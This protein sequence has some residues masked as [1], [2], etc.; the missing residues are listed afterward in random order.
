MGR[1]Q[2]EVGGRKLKGKTPQRVDNFVVY[3]PTAEER[4]RITGKA[5]SIEE[6][7]NCLIPLL[8]EGHKLTLGFKPE[9]SAYY[10]HLREG[11]ADWDKAVTLS[12]WHAAPERVFQ[13]MSDAILHKYPEFPLVQLSLGGEA[14]DW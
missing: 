13:M 14:P 10:L 11:N 6:C 12:C 9:N 8:E 7:L 5:L 1:D 3:R 2:N 4:A